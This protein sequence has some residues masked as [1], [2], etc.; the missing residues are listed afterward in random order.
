M[1]KSSSPILVKP[2]IEFTR[3]QVAAAVA[4]ATLTF[5]AGLAWNDYIVTLFNTYFGKDA[6]L[7]QRL[8]YAILVTLVS[9]YVMTRLHVPPDPSDLKA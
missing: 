3:K 8:L 1:S 5:I 6:A 7:M 9:V 2:A 4:A